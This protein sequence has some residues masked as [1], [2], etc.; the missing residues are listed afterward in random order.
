MDQQGSINKKAIF[1]SFV[2]MA[3]EV[4]KLATWNFHEA[5]HGK[6]VPGAKSTNIVVNFSTKAY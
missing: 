2:V 3:E 1:T 4:F 6:V 5:G